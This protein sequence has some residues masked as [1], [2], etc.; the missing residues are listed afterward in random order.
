MRIATSVCLLTLNICVSAAAPGPNAGTAAVAIESAIIDGKPATLSAESPLKVAE[1]ATLVEIRYTNSNLTAADQPHFRYRLQ[2]YTADWVDAGSGGV[3][4][5]TRLPPGRYRF[6]VQSGNTNGTWD[7][8]ESTLN[9][10]V[11]SS[12]PNRIRI[13]ALLSLIIV[14]VVIG[15]FYFLNDR[16]RRGTNPAS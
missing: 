8:N 3:A 2:G 9:I 11:G 12:M 4:R 1:G 15:G 6:A 13:A 5:F 16:R 10:E 7:Q 14:L